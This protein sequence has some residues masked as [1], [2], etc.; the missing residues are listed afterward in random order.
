MATQ[1]IYFEVIH[2]EVYSAAA[3]FSN[4]LCGFIENLLKLTFQSS[5]NATMNHLMNIFLA[6]NK[7]QMLCKRVQKYEKSAYEIRWSCAQPDE[8]ICFRIF[9][10]NWIWTGTNWI[11][12]E[13]YCSYDFTLRTKLMLT[14]T[15][16]FT[17]GLHSHSLLAT[18]K[19]ND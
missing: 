11:S 14:F 17:E 3:T 19:L 16:Q 2:M 18:A 9:I 4:F 5:M 8:L 12:G 6:M 7:T 10:W 15:G 13:F 1:S